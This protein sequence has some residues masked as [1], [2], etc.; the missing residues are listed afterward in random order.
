MKTTLEKTTHELEEKLSLLE[1]N[2]YPEV[3]GRIMLKDTLAILVDYDGIDFKNQMERYKLLE[4]KY[5]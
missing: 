5:K 3:L 4:R 1:S 2:S